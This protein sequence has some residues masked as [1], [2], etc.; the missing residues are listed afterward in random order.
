MHEIPD[1]RHPALA[2]GDIV[3][4]LIRVTEENRAAR[5]VVVVP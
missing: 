5:T 3:R 1:L 2:T 4:E